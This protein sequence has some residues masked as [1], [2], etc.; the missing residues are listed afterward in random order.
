LRDEIVAPYEQ[1]LAR[2]RAAP[3]IW[4]L[5][6]QAAVGRVKHKVGEAIKQVGNAIKK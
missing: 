1:L 6:T 5:K 3:S 4:N 2:V